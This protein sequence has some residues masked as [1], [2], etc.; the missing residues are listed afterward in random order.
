MENVN[1]REFLNCSQRAGLGLAAGMTILKDAKSVRAAPATRIT[2]R[3]SSSVSAAG[4]DMQR[5]GKLFCNVHSGAITFAG[6]CLK[7][8]PASAPV[9]APWASAG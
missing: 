3:I 6:L 4:V 2:K 8:R 7:A 5:L 9:A 1:R